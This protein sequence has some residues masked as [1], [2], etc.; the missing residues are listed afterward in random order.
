MGRGDVIQDFIV[1]CPVQDGETVI[2]ASDGYPQLAQTL[3]ES[4]SKLQDTID[5]DPLLINLYKST[6]GIVP[7]NVSYDDRTYIRFTVQ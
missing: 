5:K 4:E 1:T 6:K 7:G 3:A 2:L